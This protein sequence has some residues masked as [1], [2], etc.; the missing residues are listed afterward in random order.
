MTEPV[1]AFDD[2]LPPDEP[3]VFLSY[4]RKD[5]EQAQGIADALRNRHFGVFRDT[6]DIL[7]TEEWR[8]RLQQLIEEADT[9]V[10]LMSPQSVASEICAWEVE[11]ATSLNKRIAPIVIED[12]DGGDIPPLLARLNFIFCTERDPFEN[13]I[14]TL[15]SALGTDIDWVREHTRLSGLARRWQDAGRPKRLLL[16]GQDIA[17]AETWRDSRPKDSP[18]ITQ[19]HTALIRESR[20]AAQARQRGWIAGS[21]LVA[22]V[23]AGL[24]VF[25]II[26]SVEADRQRAEAEVQRTEAELQRAEAE[27]QRATAE[28]ER[29]RAETER[30]RAEEQRDLAE[31]RLREALIER[32]G[33]N[34]A[35]AAALITG[36]RQQS[37]APL[38]RQ[39]LQNAIELADPALIARAETVTRNLLLSDRSMGFLENPH[40]AEI[41]YAKVRTSPDGLHISALHLQDLKVW[42]VA[43]GHLTSVTASGVEDMAWMPD[44]RLAVVHSKR[45]TG[46][47]ASLTMFDPAT[48]ST[49]TDTDYDRQFADA[50]IFPGQDLA[51]VAEYLDGQYRT[52]GISLSG[53]RVLF[54]LPATASFR[55]AAVSPDGARIAISHDSPGG[56]IQ[57]DRAGNLVAGHVASASSMRFSP[58]GSALAYRDGEGWWLWPES[59][60]PEL[61]THEGETADQLVFLQD[62]RMLL[63][64][65]LD[66]VVLTTVTDPDDE[67]LLPV[68][69]VFGLVGTMDDG[70]RFILR[71]DQQF[72][73]H[74]SRSG[75]L[76]HRI[77][78]ISPPSGGFHLSADGRYLAIIHQDG[79]VSVWSTDSGRELL[80]LNPDHSGKWIQVLDRPS[81][82]V[83][84]VVDGADR[85]GLWR[86]EPYDLLFGQDVIGAGAPLDGVVAVG[87]T[88][89][90]P[91]RIWDMAAA[92][93]VRFVDNGFLAGTDTLA[94]RQLLKISGSEAVIADPVQSND[95]P[96]ETGG[97]FD[98]WVTAWGAN[99]RLASHSAGIVDVHHTGSGSLLARIRVSDDGT[100]PTVR[101]MAFLTPDRLAILTDDNR[102]LTADVDAGDVVSDHSLP[103]NGK[104]KEMVVSATGKFALISHDA[105]LWHH[106]F[107]NSTTVSLGAQDGT[108]HLVAAGPKASVLHSFDGDTRRSW[109]L[110]METGA[111]RFDVD[112]GAAYALGREDQIIVSEDAR[113]AFSILDARTGE[114]LH[115][116]EGDGGVGGFPVRPYLSADERWMIGVNGGADMLR[117]IDTQT[118]RVQ[119]RIGRRSGFSGA[120]QPS[121]DFSAVTLTEG[122][123]SAVLDLSA[124]RLDADELTKVLDDR[125]PELRNPPGQTDA[126]RCDRM[127]AFSNDPRARANGVAYDS[128]PVEALT[129]CGAAMAADD[130]DPTALFQFAR[131]A[132][133]HAP[134]NDRE[135]AQLL[136]GLADQ[137]YAAAGY[138][139]AVLMLQ[140]RAPADKDT[141]LGR[142][143]D[144]AEAGAGIAW[145][146]LSRLAAAGHLDE[147]ADEILQKGVAAGLPAAMDEKARLLA[148]QGGHFREAAELARKAAQA[149]ATR[150]QK[151]V[152][153]AVMQ[154]AAGYAR[155][156][157][158]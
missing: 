106:D 122:I 52:L 150:Y 15:S 65:G 64:F 129:V 136:A 20:R 130:A 18:D 30:Q 89:S 2:D 154:R 81:G 117:L 3:K 73:V 11:Y 146:L 156:H 28:S 108:V 40:V 123:R 50:V 119:A 36:G 133:L 45:R 82:P 27:R 44:N 105:G 158:P 26:Q 58:D 145:V 70:D 139:L 131:A 60:Q 137:G 46:A 125:F 95:V 35:D 59:D 90:E 31:R 116:E 103:G 1:P 121:V 100:R 79:F 76:I 34:L 49:T 93:P 21:L 157:R 67:R 92:V 51:V 53:G 61:L 144:S 41:G 88:F 97:R 126:S 22:L 47:W 112:W 86:I 55:S 151:T 75:D 24:S 42:S 109:L 38:A 78:R 113:G 149:Y 85:L 9:I 110:D 37:A 17:D 147:P 101:S 8:E 4:S 71:H 66:Q 98:A 39:A 120:L 19:G 134:E 99:D 118:G 13:A 80:A 16:R 68:T 25:A 33:R 91:M 153:E 7:P 63:R 14:E 128:I 54:D 140:G 62:D 143:E 138:S 56:I 77:G 69:S 12:V 152:A 142:L 29:D 102:L 87:G 6:D 5:R 96:L 57:I 141:L 104:A 127:A 10:F 115:S 72:A 23:T 84:A 94:G 48:G 43:T 107:S 155:R 135:T 132:S 83:L 32:T 111:T 114:V 74:D 124:A 148:A